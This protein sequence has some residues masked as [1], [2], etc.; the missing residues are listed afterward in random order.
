MR[1]RPARLVAARSPRSPRSPAGWYPRARVRRDGRGRAGVPRRR[2]IRD[3]QYWLDEYGIA[4]AWATTR[5]A[6]VTIAIIDSGVDDDAPDLRG[7]VVG[8]STSRGVGSPDGTTPVGRGQR[9]RHDGRLARGR[10]RRGRRGRAR[11]GSG[12][13]PA[14][15]VA[16]FRH[17]RAA[18]G[19]EQI[20]EAVRWAVDQGA[21]IISLSLTRNTVEWPESWDDAF[22][23]AEQNDVVVIAAAGNRGSG[24]EQVGAPATMPGVLAVG[25]R[26]PQR[27]RERARLIA[28][29]LHRRHG[30]ERATR[31][32]R[33]RRRVR[34]V[35][36][37][38]RSDPD[39]RRH[40][41]ARAGRRIP[42]LDAAE[43]RSSAS[44]A[45]RAPSPRP[46]PTRST[47]TGSS[48]RAAAVADDVPEVEA[49]PLGSIAEWITINRRAGRLDADRDGDRCA[50]ADRPCAPPPT[51]SRTRFEDA[52]ERVRPARARSRSSQLIAVL[53]A[54]CQ[55]RS[56]SAARGSSGARRKAVDWAGP[57]PP[58]EIVPSCPES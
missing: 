22:G 13:L 25:G 21:D 3:R 34:H 43:R 40:R 33:S 16:R 5:G 18:R 36:G 50:P 27:R 8:G 56:S 20:A 35:A 42:K 23:Y 47:G 14:D 12:G 30:A 1:S 19:D 24:T 10:A 48:T 6:G 26:R 39:R 44:S 7:A 45:P 31:R 2:A 38:E 54:V 52:R 58:K 49:N 4:D 11:C 53:A 55:R 41:R 57:S 37:H 28:G 9:P 17:H 51:P 32:R 46:C 15:R 29:H